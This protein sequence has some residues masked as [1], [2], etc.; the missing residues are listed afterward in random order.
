MNPIKPCARVL[1]SPPPLPAAA[2]GD[3]RPRRPHLA[4]SVRPVP[5]HVTYRV[6][7][8]SM[9]HAHHARTSDSHG[10]VTLNLTLMP[11]VTSSYPRAR[12][13]TPGGSLG[14]QDY[15]HTPTHVFFAHFV[16]TR[17][18]PKRISWLVT[19][20]FFRMK[21]QSSFEWAF[22]EKVVLSIL[23]S[24][25]PECYTPP[26]LDTVEH[27]AKAWRCKF[28]SGTAPYICE[29]SGIYY[30]F[31][32]HMYCVSWVIYIVQW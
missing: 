21:P 7:T 22:G 11:I 2:L 32:D 14:A 29:K 17:A 31:V 26:I 1:L 4:M 27:D 15:P 28:R 24:S 20:E 6:P 13:L 8:G 5:A 9:H 23:L 25:G 19:L 16:R 10:L 3:R 12:P 18:H 30:E